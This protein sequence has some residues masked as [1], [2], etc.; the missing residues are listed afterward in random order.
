MNGGNMKNAVLL[1]VSCALLSLPACG[2]GGN[3]GGGTCTGT[4]LE[5]AEAAGDAFVTVVEACMP[6]NAA[7]MIKEL[8]A[9]GGVDKTAISL[10]PGGTC[11]GGGTA[12]V[13]SETFILTLTDCKAADGTAF[14]G[15]MQI[16]QV[17]GLASINLT[18]FGSCCSGI[19]GEGIQGDP[20]VGCSGTVT[21]TCSGTAIGCQL[22][23]PAEGSESC[24]Y[25]CS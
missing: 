17:T 14:N 23:A 24:D 5:Q 12:T 7:Q 6:Q 1:I 8:A 21:G 4:P 13:D 25:T 19:T 16:D 22:T 18:Q 3:G 2:G 20:T 10:C 9:G 11:P 15:T